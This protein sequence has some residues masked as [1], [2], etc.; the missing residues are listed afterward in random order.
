MT[1]LVVA[2]DEDQYEDY[3]AEN[4]YSRDEYKLV[5]GLDSILGYEWDILEIT[6]LDAGAPIML[7]KYFQSMLEYVREKP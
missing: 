2:R 3:L 6:V 4:G 7:N 5:R 1:V